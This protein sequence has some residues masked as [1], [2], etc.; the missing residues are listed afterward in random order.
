MEW[1]EKLPFYS[2]AEKF[3]FA[4]KNV[5]SFDLSFLRMVPGWNEYHKRMKTGHR[6]MD[7]GPIFAS[8]FFDSQPPDL[9]ECMGRATVLGEVNHRALDDATDVLNVLERRSQPYRHTKSGDIYE[10]VE[11]GIVNANDD[12][13]MILYRNKEGHLFVRTEVEF[14]EKFEQL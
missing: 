8:M 1:L 4:G 5:G 14:F 3:T 6:M 7:P 13:R 9:K 11:K 10:V 12:V 2:K